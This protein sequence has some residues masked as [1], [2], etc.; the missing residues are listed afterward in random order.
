MRE[1]SRHPLARVLQPEQ[2]K[3]IIDRLVGVELLVR[4][5]VGDH[6]PGGAVYERSL[7][8]RYPPEDRLE[9]GGLADAIFPE[10]ADAL[11][12]VEG[13]LGYE[14]EG[15]GPPDET[16]LHRAHLLSA[17]RPVAK[18]IMRSF[19]R[20]GRLDALDLVQSALPTLGEARP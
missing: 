9:E 10:D 15:I 20:Y 16:F 18:H 17:A 7:Q 13:E 11:P 14:E 12:R 4:L 3:V 2:S 5:R 19:G 1:H 6:L 8:E